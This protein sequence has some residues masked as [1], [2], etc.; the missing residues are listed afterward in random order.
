[1]V[2]EFDDYEDAAWYLSAV[3]EDEEIN[4]LMQQL[5]VFPLVISEHN[6]AL[7]RSGFTI[8]DYLTYK[9]EMESGSKEETEN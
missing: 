5:Q 8:E 4:K 9:A 6:F 2:Y 7:T 1:S 3:S